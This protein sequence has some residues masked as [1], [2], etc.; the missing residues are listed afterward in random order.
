MMR[1]IKTGGVFALALGLAALQGPAPA[2]AGGGITMTLTPD[3]DTADVIQQGLAIYSLVQQFKGNNHAKVNQKG[4][5]NAAAVGQHGID[6]YGLVYQRGR[7]HTATLA[8]TGRNNALG[9]LQ[10]GRNT[11]L[12]VAQYGQGQVGLVLQGGW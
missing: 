3:G 12:D 7:D 10:F 2:L 6:N 8:Q 5:G 1:S 4:H 9:V 11:H